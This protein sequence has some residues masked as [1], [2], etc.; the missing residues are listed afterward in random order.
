MGFLRG[1]PTGLTVVLAIGFESHVAIDISFVVP[2]RG[3]VD[4]H[5]WRHHHLPPAAACVYATVW[6][7]FRAGNVTTPWSG[8]QRTSEPLARGNF[9][10]RLPSPGPPEAPVRHDLLSIP[11]ALGVHPLLG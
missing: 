8:V 2:I 1:Y 9:S 4:V 7:W 6:L 10:Q 5:S 3:V 11:S